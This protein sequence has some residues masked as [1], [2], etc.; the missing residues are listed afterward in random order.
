MATIAVTGAS[1]KLGSA[2]IGFLLE[3]KVAPANI[4]A[5]VRDP[6]KVMALAAQG[7]EIRRGDYTDPA[8]LENALRGVD[9][10]AFISSSALG[11]ER[12]LHHGNVVKAAKLAR[13][14]HIFYTSVIK[15]AAQAKFAASPGHYFTEQLILGSGLAHTFF[16][17]NLYMDLVPIMFGGALA[18]GTLAHNGG[19][20]RIGF[21][22]RQDIAAALAAVL[23]S[24][25]HAG[26]A[27]S[28]TAPRPHG[29][30][31][32]AAA[33]AKASGSRVVY[34]SLTSDEFR[35]R[36]S[37]TPMPPAIVEMSVALGEALRAGEFDAESD[38]CARLLGR[39]PATLQ[40][41]LEKA[42]GTQ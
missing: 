17:N 5:I 9:R 18:T 23:T 42:R 26:R 29:L 36:L 33:L 31:D 27:Y 25:G 16:R 21:I 15:P 6:A 19:D 3:R 20:G 38:D 32:I 14:G 30:G 34:E 12:V 37:A 7:V 41:F 22:A 24:E 4:I 39:E 13:V 8:S 35:T 2:T 40:A 11:E 28:I 1:G 10:L